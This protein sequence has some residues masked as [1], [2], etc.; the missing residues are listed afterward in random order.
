MNL[1]PSSEIERALTRACMTVYIPPYNASDTLYI[2]LSNSYTGLNNQI[3]SAFGF[4]APL[5]CSRKN[6][7]QRALK[8]K[9]CSNREI[10]GDA[11]YERFVIPD[12]SPDQTC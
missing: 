12:P 2:K 4:E 1:R 3:L 10:L 5:S 7:L 9:Y 11:V 6:D 8:I